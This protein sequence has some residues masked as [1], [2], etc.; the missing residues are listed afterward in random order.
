MMALTKEIALQV[1]AALELGNERFA[2][3][4]KTC[5]CLVC[6]WLDMVLKTQDRR[7]K[8][9]IL[10]YITDRAYGKPTV[11]VQ[12]KIGGDGSGRPIII[13]SSVPRPKHAA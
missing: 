9:E 8:F 10:K 12:A 7:L 4:H 13:Q 1:L 2:K 5:E 3:Q 6:Q 11:I